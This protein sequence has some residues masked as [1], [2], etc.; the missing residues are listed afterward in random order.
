M[1]Y[2]E[3][4]AGRIRAILTNQPDMVEKKMFGGVG[5]LLKGNMATGV[6]KDMLVVR[7]GPDDYEQMMTLPHTRPFDMTGR[8]MK[9]W[10][11]V[12]PD[13]FESQAD[14]ERWVQ[15]GLQ[16]ALTLPPK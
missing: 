1:A 10:L 13:G 12:E 11:L 4:L 2:D 15:S 14:L 16:F 7:V 6:H 8:E 5:F 9:G 3:I